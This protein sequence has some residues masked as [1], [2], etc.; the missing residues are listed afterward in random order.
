MIIFVAD[1]FKEDYIG[2][3][4]LT[5]E[6]LIEDYIYPS[7]KVRSQELTPSLIKKYSDNFWV[8][9]NFS[10]ISPNLLLNI[11]KNINYAVVEYDYKF[12]KFRSVKKHIAAEGSCNCHVEYT[13]KIASIFFA[14]AKSIFW[15]SKKQQQIYLERFSFL[16]ESKNVVLNSVFD[17][18]T[19]EYF[20]NIKLP[21]KNNKWLI[22]NS[23]SWI[24]GTDDAVE[25][26][27]ENQLEFEIV[28]NLSYND[29][30]KKIA[31][32]KG[33]IFLPKAG[34]TCPR[35]VIEAQLLGC[36][37]ILNDNVQHKDE[38]WF[39]NSH[40]TLEHMESRATF[41]WQ[42]IVEINTEYIS[43][44]TSNKESKGLHYKIIIPF[45]N[46]EKWISTCIR[47]VKSQDY[48]D[49]MC[50]LVDD[51]S[52]DN[53]LSI[54]REEIKGDPRF[55]LIVNEQK[56]YAL[57][58][59]YEG[60]QHTNPN[61]EDVIVTLDGDDWLASNSVLSILNDEYEEHGCWITYGNYIEYPSWTHG[62]F[63]TNIPQKVIEENSFRE[64][65]WMSSHL[66]SFKYKIWRNI[67]KE[68]LLDSTGSFYRMSWDMAFMFPMLEMA[69]EKQKFISKT[70]YVYNRDNPLNDDKIDNRLQIQTENHIRSKDKY[71]K[72]ERIK[73]DLSDC[74]FIIP[75][76]VE[77][78][79]RKFNI[80]TTVPY[81]LEN[82][83]TNII[84]HET[85]EE[86]SQISD[87]I[88]KYGDNIKVISNKE[89]NNVPY[90]RTKYLN[91]M[92]DKVQTPITINYDS[93]I[94]L[95]ISSYIEAA[96]KIRTGKMDLVYPFYN[97]NYK[98]ETGQNTVCPTCNHE[99]LYFMQ[100]QY[101]IFQNNPNREKL[102]Q[103]LDLSVLDLEDKDAMYDSAYGFCQFFNTKSYRE[104]FKE[105]E[106]FI[107][108]GPED[109]ERYE[110][111][112]RLGYDVCHLEGFVYHL[113]HSR[114]PD[115]W[116][117]NTHFNHNNGLHETIKR[118]SNKEL[119]EYYESQDYLKEKVITEE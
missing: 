93:D 67:K 88:E 115:S 14:K 13:G 18:P 114:T 54:I 110:R 108:Y 26:A 12:C 21:K 65:Q 75:L 36:E 31:E 20:K 22:L 98:F 70:L 43:L 90:H 94:L 24:K 62:K 68:D 56:K 104:G 4:E 113:E 116:V 89:P 91:L 97:S 33:L 8:F 50:V 79:D 80:S 6:A 52:T 1:A 106:N 55:K 17:K 100:G 2:G 60:I 9:G 96:E 28:N 39:E 105:N 71:Q 82:F 40:T 25:Y 112:S 73:H 77:S 58:N 92:L 7:I 42:K 64:H 99:T 117:T 84:I 11:A 10:L 59:I 44:P 87:L 3:A 69:G 48:K 61:D 51:M 49:F 86:H 16:K 32:S 109:Y 85:F 63:S 30:L 78:E 118:L 37:L 102:R 47:S 27:K 35:I 38:P 111:F 23:S 57:Q 19:L 34:D 41:F 101:R 66:R 107:A 81:I 119:V 76:K 95:P 103:T 46:V 29:M 45:Y 72:I 53:S 74:T 5:T 15:M 83:I